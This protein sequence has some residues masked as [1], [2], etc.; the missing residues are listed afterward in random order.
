MF[1][2]IK[3][4]CVQGSVLGP[5][6]FSL[7]MSPLGDLDF[8]RIFSYA[9]DTYNGFS[10]R[11]YQEIAMEAEQKLKLLYHWLTKSGM[12][13]NLEKTECCLFSRTDIHARNLNIDGQEIGVKKKIKILGVTFD[14]KLTWEIQVEEACAKAKRNLHALKFL[15]RF[16]NSSELSKIATHCVFGALYYGC[17]IWL[18]Q[19]TK[20]K[21]IQKLN[22]VS[23]TCLRIC[24]KDWRR[25]FNREILHKEFKRATPTEMGHY[26]LARTLRNILLR[27]CS[28]QFWTIFRKKEERLK[29]F[30]L[31][32][33]IV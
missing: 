9:D 33:K 25:L 16:F 32:E 11:S 5:F 4:G 28:L 19:Q 3:L 6:I 24:K 1:Y 31:Q 23:T 8:G 26:V 10:G 20:R 15:S 29:E 21:S 22:T 14:S 18:G 7:F 13:V 30:L 27:I 17:E 12:F 2:E